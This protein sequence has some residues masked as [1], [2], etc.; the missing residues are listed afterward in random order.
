MPSR[1]PSVTF[2]PRRPSGSPDLTAVA[3][4]GS[5]VSSSLA[6]SRDRGTSLM[7]SAWCGGPGVNWGLV[8]AAA[9]GWRCA[10]AVRIAGPRRCSS[11]AGSVSRRTSVHHTRT[12]SPGTGQVCA[13]MVT[14]S[15]RCHTRYVG[16]DPRAQLSG[17]LSRSRPSAS[18]RHAGSAGPARSPH[19]GVGSGGC[20]SAPLDDSVHAGP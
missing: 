7:Q 18:P 6:D 4:S 19:A 8:R 16:P 17:S 9:V 2:R 3:V 13:W 10:R 12:T 14:A 5:Y 20:Q 11:M 1:R 15:R